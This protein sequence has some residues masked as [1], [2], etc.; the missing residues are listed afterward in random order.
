MADKRIPDITI[1]MMREQLVGQRVAVTGYKSVSKMPDGSY[2]YGTVKGTCTF[3]G[4]NKYFPSW[5]LC[6][7]VDGM[8][9]SNITVGQITVI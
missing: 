9:L 1:E 7:T 8:P 3:F 4:Y 2:N 5:E 6:I